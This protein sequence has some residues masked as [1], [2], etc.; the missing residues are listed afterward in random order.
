MNEFD[1]QS[2]RKKIK[3]E[4]IEVNTDFHYFLL[5]VKLLFISRVLLGKYR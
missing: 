5:N 3:R 2:L 1:I 4:P